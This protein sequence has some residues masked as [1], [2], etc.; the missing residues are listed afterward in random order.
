MAYSELE[1]KT[2]NGLQTKSEKENRDHTRGLRTGRHLRFND[3]KE[4]EHK[5]YQ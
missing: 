1:K 5:D 4:T 2:R 3:E